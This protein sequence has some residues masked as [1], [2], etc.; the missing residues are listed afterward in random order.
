MSPLI[1]P[2]S[3]RGPAAS[4]QRQHDNRKLSTLTDDLV[5]Y[6]R[7]CQSRSAAIET[8]EHGAQMVDR[9]SKGYE[10]EG[11]VRLQLVGAELNYAEGRSTEVETLCHRALT[12]VSENDELLNTKFQSECSLFARHLLTLTHLRRGEDN[13]ANDLTSTFADTDVSSSAYDF[14]SQIIGK[15]SRRGM[16]AVYEGM[17]GLLDHSLGARDLA[18]ESYDKVAETLGGTNVAEWKD[19]DAKLDHVAKNFAIFSSC[20]GDGFGGP[21]WDGRPDPLSQYDHVAAKAAEG[22][23]GLAADQK[24]SAVWG[25]H[26]LLKEVA[27]S[28][29]FAAAQEL[30][31]RGD[32]DAAEAR[33]ESLLQSHAE[34]FSGEDSRAGLVVTK[35]AEVYLKSNRLTLAEGLFRNAGKLL[36]GGQ[37]SI[38]D[39]PSAETEC[40]PSCAALL[41][42]N[43]SKLLRVIPRREAEAARTLERAEKRWSERVCPHTSLQ[44]V[45]GRGVVDLQTQRLLYL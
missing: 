36:G 42:L 29:D 10:V 26:A 22:A 33:L 17:K 24:A 45:S 27:H 34:E 41:E 12:L 21:D 37:V 35:L 13:L 6:A 18:L 30:V 31:N 32:L 14:Q 5:A 43:Y 1:L 15:K 2:F 4:P 38:L 40:H 44:D 8:V 9:D 28:A 16:A 19:K 11:V 25:S 3:V 39:D 20:L 7:Q 23:R